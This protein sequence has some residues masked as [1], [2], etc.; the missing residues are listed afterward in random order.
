MHDIA[1]VV[2]QLGITATVAGVW[3]WLS[4]K[5]QEMVSI[6]IPIIV[7]VATAWGLKIV[8]GMFGG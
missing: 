7:A 5:K 8:P 1:A 4:V 6:P 2:A 3:A